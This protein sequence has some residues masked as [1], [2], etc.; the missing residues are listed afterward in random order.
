MISSFHIFNF[1]QSCDYGRSVSDDEE[2][3][4]TIKNVL[5]EYKKGVVRANSLYALIIY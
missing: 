2:Y 1:V 4:E 3:L 5:R